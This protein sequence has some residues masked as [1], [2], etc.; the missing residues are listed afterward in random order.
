VQVQALCPGL[1]ATEFHEQV[2]ADPASFPP[3]IVMSS[4]DVVQASLAGLALG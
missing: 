2:G 4:E 1:V 3:G